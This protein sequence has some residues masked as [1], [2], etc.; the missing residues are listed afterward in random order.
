MDWESILKIEPNAV[1]CAL[2]QSGMLSVFT[3]GPILGPSGWFPTNGGKKVSLGLAEISSNF[4]P[5]GSLQIRPGFEDQVNADIAKHNRCVLPVRPKE[6][7]SFDSN[8]TPA[9][10]VLERE[11]QRLQEV[12]TV[13]P[14]QLVEESDPVPLVE[15]SKAPVP[16]LKELNDSMSKLESD[17]RSVE[18]QMSLLT[19]LLIDIGNLLPKTKQT[20]IAQKLSEIS[21]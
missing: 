12:A 3:T 16:T 13:N 8:T 21:P 19:D 1:A 6:V 17:I 4:S 7:A 15:E 9:A 10:A 11:E 5:G 2:D 20:K 14:S 18:S